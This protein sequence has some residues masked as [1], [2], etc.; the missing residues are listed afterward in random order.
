MRKI[1]QVSNIFLISIVLLIS[2]NFLLGWI[3]EI[4]TK[5]KFKNFEPY[6]EIFV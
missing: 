4:R 2:I 1:Q 6:Y 3:W 5:I